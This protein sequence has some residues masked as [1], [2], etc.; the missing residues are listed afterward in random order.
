VSEQAKLNITIWAVHKLYNA[1]NGHFITTPPYITLFNQPP[2]YR[3][4]TL[5]SAV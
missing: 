4:P 3:T 5:I 2:N 1:K